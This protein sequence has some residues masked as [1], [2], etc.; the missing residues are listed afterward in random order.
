MLM[1][2]DQGTPAIKVF[3]NALSKKY[4]SISAFNNT[5]NTFYHAFDEVDI[6][7]IGVAYL[8]GHQSAQEDVRMFNALLARR[9]YSTTISAINRYAPYHMTLGSRFPTTAER[10]VLQI[11]NGVGDAMSIN[12]YTKHIGTVQLETERISRYTH[13]PVIHSEICWLIEGRNLPYPGVPIHRDRG[14][15]WHDFLLNEI[16]WNWIAGMCWYGYM[17]GGWVGHGTSDVMNFGL[18]D[19]HDNPYTE[20]VEWVVKGNRAAMKVFAKLFR[21]KR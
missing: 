11:L 17:D 20:A 4:D 16:T 21:Q 8:G 14:E 7:L 5:Y 18:I 9:I 2:Q 1:L 10:E 13:L 15:Y 19:I 12:H 6:T 3:Q